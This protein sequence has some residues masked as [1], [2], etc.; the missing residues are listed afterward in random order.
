MNQLPTSSADHPPPY[1]NT[2]QKSTYSQLV[3][4]L[5]DKTTSKLG[6]YSTS[7]SVDRKSLS[8]GV[9][10]VEIA[11]DEFETG[12][13][14]IGLDVYLAG[15]DKIIMAL[16]KGRVGI[17]T[18][19]QQEIADV[20]EDENH[21][22]TIMDKFQIITKLIAP[23]SW[24]IATTQGNNH[25]TTDTSNTTTQCQ[26]DAPIQKFK[27]LNKVMTDKMI[28]CVVLFKRSPVPGNSHS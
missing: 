5:I 15:L 26:P 11:V 8:Q 21:T 24:A 1:N 2:A 10:L 4:K 9:K 28:H 7:R 16:P 27:L 6:Y 19:Q 17:S 13:E 3:D 22:D 23:S 12:N 18:Q 20:E 14:A 25:T